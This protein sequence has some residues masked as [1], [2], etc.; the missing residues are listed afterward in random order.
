MHSQ[1]H[2]DNTDIDFYSRTA[3]AWDAMYDDCAAATRSIEFEQYIL[4]D[5]DAGRRFLDLFADK[6]AAGVDVKL[7]LDAIGSRSLAS[8]PATHK[9]RN[10]G[11]KV[12][13]YNEINRSNMFKPTRWFPRTHNKT[14]LID[15]SIGYI[16]S[17]CLRDTM[18]DWRDMHARFT[19][20]LAQDVKRNFHRMWRM[21]ARNVQIP[22]PRSKDNG[23]L[24]RY[25]TTQ[26][27]QR[28]N[29]LY[30]ELLRR[31][32]KAKHRI[33]IATP[34]FLPPWRLRRALRRAARRGIDIRILTSGASDVS[35][36]DCVA[37][38]FYPRF[39]RNNMRIFHYGP[40]MLHAKYVLI[41]DDW[42]TL[43]STNMDYLS[44]MINREANII[45]HQSKTIARMAQ[46]FSKDCAISDSIDHHYY[47]RLPWLRKIIGWL[48]RSIRRFL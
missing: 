46:Q 48:G 39:L 30:Q 36:V 22:A 6:A 14:L 47:D 16:G 41:D 15:G 19:G 2:H 43:G 18:R 29:N 4:M 26:H 21:A 10:A 27:W 28:S 33:W 35:L 17:V 12:Y 24:F 9:I 38:S 8:S 45:I 37:Q 13:F 3:D 7:M 44:L 11:G 40:E 34:Y 5:D 1:E 20:Q 32:K 42:A 25:V 31:I 23:G